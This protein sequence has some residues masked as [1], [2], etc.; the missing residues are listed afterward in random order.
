MSQKTPERR[1]SDIVRGLATEVRRDQRVLEEVTQAVFMNTRELRS[2]IKDSIRK[3]QQLGQRKQ[4][5]N[6]MLDRILEG[7]QEDVQDVN[8]VLHEF[9][10]SRPDSDPLGVVLT[11]LSPD[12]QKRYR[13]T[14][15]INQ[16]RQ[17]VNMQERMIGQQMSM[18]YQY[19][20]DDST[21]SVQNNIN[22]LVTGTIGPR[23][24]M[25]KNGLEKRTKELED[26]IS[27]IRGSTEDVHGKVQFLISQINRLLPQDAMRDSRSTL[28]E[29]RKDLFKQMGRLR[30]FYNKTRMLQMSGGAM[31]Y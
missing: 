6:F 1:V 20:G 17:Q 16:V 29:M 9:T 28:N 19:G 24:E 13:L 2:R 14:E 7:L 31:M 8:E 27:K 18:S 5:V 4:N 21:Q 22:S 30:G 25:I 11:V 26:I 12:F 10:Q 23:L 15:S 3:L